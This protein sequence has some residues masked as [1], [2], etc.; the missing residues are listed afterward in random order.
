MCMLFCYYPPQESTDS[1]ISLSSRTEAASECIKCLCSSV[2]GSIME[3]ISWEFY[4]DRLT[5]AILTTQHFP[6]QNL[7]Y[8]IICRY[9]N[10]YL[11]TMISQSPSNVCFIIPLLFLSRNHPSYIRNR[12]ENWSIVSIAILELGSQSKFSTIA[13]LRRTQVKSYVGL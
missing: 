1:Q 8:W 4:F 2:P 7:L 12:A 6:L 10:L 13:L 3:C 9:T 5:H 11:L